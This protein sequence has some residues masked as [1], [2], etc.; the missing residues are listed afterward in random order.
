MCQLLQNISYLKKK[1][2]IGL[3]KV[4]NIQISVCGDHGS[5]FKK[6]GSIPCGFNTMGTTNIHISLP[7]MEEKNEMQ[8]KK[9]KVEENI[10]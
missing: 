2:L 10:L 6:V 4:I 5:I 7:E 9:A 1:S 3:F 8:Q